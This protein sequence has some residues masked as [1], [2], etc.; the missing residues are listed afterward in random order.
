MTTP[1]QSTQDKAVLTD[2]DT[3]I[4]DSPYK[5]LFE[6]SNAPMLLLDLQNNK[7]VEYNPAAKRK[8]GIDERLAA[9][10]QPADVSPQYQPDGALSSEKSV[11]YIQE[12]MGAWFCT[13]RM[14][15]F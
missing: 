7:F 2:P 14:A 5:L 1:L 8:I 13:L 3:Y 10:L 6:R 15:A 11:L 4:D 12:A 9:P